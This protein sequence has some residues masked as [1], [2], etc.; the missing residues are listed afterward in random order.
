MPSWRCLHESFCGRLLGDSGIRILYDPLQ[1]QVLLWRSC[2][3]LLWSWHEDLAQGLLRFL[4]RRSCGDPSEMLSGAFAWSCTGPWEALEEILVKSSR[5]P[6]MIWHRPLWED[7]VEIVL[8]SSSR[9]PCIKISKVLCIG[10][11]ESSSGM[12]IASSCLKI[13]WAPLLIYI[14]GPAAAVA[15]M[16]NLICYCSLLLLVSGTLTSYPPHRLGPLAGVI[17]FFTSNCGRLLIWASL[18]VASWYQA[19]LNKP[20]LNKYQG[21][22]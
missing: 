2:E 13:F 22:I 8:K 1:Q 17:R 9:G 6:Y 5:C 11:Y 20:R 19:G 15:I 10:A 4:V 21:A 16:S 7:L 14:E 18:E 12:L 3:I